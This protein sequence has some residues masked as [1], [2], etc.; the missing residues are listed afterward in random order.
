[1]QNDFISPVKREKDGKTLVA[2]TGGIGSGKSAVTAVLSDLG[3]PVLSADEIY[4]NLLD[5]ESFVLK[6]CR[7]IGVPPL[8]KD[9]K[10][11]I[12]RKKISELVY[13]DRMQKEK[14]DRM[15]H[16][17]I[18]REMLRLAANSPSGIVFCEVPLLYEGGY[19]DLFDYVFIVKR[20]DEQR[21]RS[22]SLRDGRSIEEARRIAS[23][24]YDY[25]KTDL[26]AHTLEIENDGDFS[27]LRQKVCNVVDVIKKDIFPT[28]KE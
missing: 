24:Q 3:F 21:F 2:V 20:D 1:M 18:M 10:F 13:S 15:T 25:T 17:P 11:F 5:E 23:R 28:K 19:R 16:P 22:V 27:L 14:L 4:R 7:E 12:D 9:G 8:E 26:D 6:V